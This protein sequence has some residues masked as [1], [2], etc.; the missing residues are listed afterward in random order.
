[1]SSLEN[2]VLAFENSMLSAE[3][4]LSPLLKGLEEQLRQNY[5]KPQTERATAT[6]TP[7]V[8]DFASNIVAFKEAI[9]ADR[10]ALNE[11]REAIL[12]ARDAFVSAQTQPRAQDSGSPISAST[13]QSLVSGM[14]ATRNSISANTLAMDGVAAKLSSTDSALQRTIETMASAVTALNTQSSG[15]TYNVEIHQHGFVVQSKSDADMT[16]RSAASAFRTGI[17]NGGS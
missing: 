4:T 13:I 10:A 16:A 12:L 1:M 2:T 7:D 5:D 9:D 14:D 15:T 3:D 17:G 11:V 6:A 8:Q